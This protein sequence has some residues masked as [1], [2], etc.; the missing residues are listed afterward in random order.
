[1]LLYFVSECGLK[2]E[3]VKKKNNNKKKNVNVGGFLQDQL[4]CTFL[5]ASASWLS[6][7]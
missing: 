1:L 2:Q 4:G 3:F 6:G 5:L 7:E